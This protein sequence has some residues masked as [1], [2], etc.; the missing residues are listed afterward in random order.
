MLQAGLVGAFADRVPKAV[1]AAVEIIT[2]AVR[3]GCGQRPDRLACLARRPATAS[4]PLA[5][6][7]RALAGA[8]C[9]VCRCRAC[10]AGVA[11]S[12]IQA[13]ERLC[14]ACSEFGCK[15]MPA[16]PILA[17]LPKLFEAK[18][19]PVRDA[20]KKLM[21]RFALP[22]A[23]QSRVWTSACRPWLEPARLLSCPKR[24]QAG[25]P[26]L[27]KAI[28]RILERSEH[29]CLDCASV[30]SQRTLQVELSSWVGVDTVRAVLGEKMPD[31]MRKDFERILDEA[32]ATRKAPSRFTRAVQAQRAQQAA[33]A[34]PAIAEADGNGHAAAAVVPEPDTAQVGC[35]RQPCLSSRSPPQ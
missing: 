3:W 32:G 34:G 20:V 18:Q 5:A 31:A 14:G 2:Q 10:S 25:G 16:K 21:V 9:A 8:R 30:P 6:S 26:P 4:L 33:A 11:L 13:A 12:R 15:A 29:T 28:Q 24:P 22:A 35:M 17:A 7:R 27:C 1:Q 19:E 23:S